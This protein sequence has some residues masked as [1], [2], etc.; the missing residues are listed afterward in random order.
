ME[1]NGVSYNLVM[2]LASE[3]GFEL[4]TAFASPKNFTSWLGL[5]PNKRITG[6]KI[7]SSKTTK[8]KSRLAQA[9]RQAAN[10]IGRQ[11]ETAMSDF[12]KRLSHKKGRK[13]A[14]TA[15]ARK[16]AVVV[17]KM[18]V[19]KE[20]YQPQGVA[21]YREKVRLQKLKY[22]QR[23]IKQLEIKAEEIAFN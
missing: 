3:V 11:K 13:I 1:I 7:L 9:F 4:A 18:L 23:T 19:N 8:K 16:L 22:I 5:S 15:T 14:I 17:Y 21:D 12:F 10:A 6:G 2:T 20:K